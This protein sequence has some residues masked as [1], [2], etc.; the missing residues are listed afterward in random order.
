MGVCLGRCGCLFM[1][2]LPSL[3][4]G[5]SSQEGV[6]DRVNGLLQVLNED[7]LPG[8]H[9]LLYHIHVAVGNGWTKS[10]HKVTGEIATKC[11]VNMI[12]V[13]AVRLRF[14]FS[15]AGVTRVQ[16]YYKANEEIYSRLNYYSL[17]AIAIGT[18]YIM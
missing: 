6:Y 8:D 2:T 16:V 14:T 12:L 13:V 15:P 7:R 17:E 1:R 11:A 4:D 3:L 9:R 10:K 18:R 5:V